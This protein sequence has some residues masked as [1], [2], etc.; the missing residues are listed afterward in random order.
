MLIKFF[1][2]LII[3]IFLSIL[4]YLYFRY[5]PINNLLFPKCPLLQT[6]GI[7]C[8]GC[9]SQRATHALLHFDLINVFK[10]NLLFLPTILLV[11]YHVG[12]Q[13]INKILNTHYTSI[14]DHSKAPVV[15]LVVVILFW[16]LRNLPYF[17]FS[18][19]AP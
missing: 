8:P 5:D 7:Y 14:L 18:Y 17:P 13:I 15:T 12:I 4:G 6:T 16:I 10:I 19:L 3:F 9:G 1:K 2:L 11:M